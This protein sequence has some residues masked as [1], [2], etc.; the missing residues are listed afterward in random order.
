MLNRTPEAK[1]KRS[2]KPSAAYVTR[3]LLQVLLP[4]QRLLVVLLQQ[5]VPSL[6]PFQGESRLQGLI[7]AGN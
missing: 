4:G 3:L 5:N 7:R 6:D 1:I 2:Q